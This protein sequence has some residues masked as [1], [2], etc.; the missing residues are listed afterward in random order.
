MQFLSFVHM[1]L[2]KAYRARIKHPAITSD[3]KFVQSLFTYI[4]YVDV[5]TI[6]VAPPY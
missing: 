1:H 5:P 2:T 4:Y 6:A 3:T